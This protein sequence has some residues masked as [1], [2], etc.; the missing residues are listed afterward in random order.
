MKW[1]FLVLI[2]LGIIGIGNAARA[3]TRALEFIVCIDPGHPSETSDGATGNGLSENTLNWQVAQRLAA[4]LKARGVKYVMTKTSLHQRVTNRRRAEIANGDNIYHQPCAIFL[5]LHCDTGSGRGYTW[6]YPS[7]SAR[8]GNVVGPPAAICAVSGRAARI[9]NAGM[10]SILAGH[11]KDNPVKTDKSTFVGSK[12]GALTGS[13]Y[14]LVPTALIEMCF[15]N[16]EHDARFIASAQGREL[17]AHA[18]VNGIL[19]WKNQH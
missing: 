4:Q 16:Q 3:S 1:K 8:K 17:M 5:R 6:Y 13:I 18:I 15:I 7:A 12:Q 10:K 11:L 9:I 19:A 2:L 14:S